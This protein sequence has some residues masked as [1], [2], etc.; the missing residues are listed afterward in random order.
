MKVAGGPET[1]AGLD[2]GEPTAPAGGPTNRATAAADAVAAAKRA[3]A[4][5]TIR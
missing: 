5:L 4:R 2:Q 1:V 3:G